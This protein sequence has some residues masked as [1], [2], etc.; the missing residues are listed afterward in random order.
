MPRF[1]LVVLVVLDSVGCGDAPDAAE[2]GDVG[3]N[4]LAH[5]IEAAGPQLPHLARLGLGSIPG[6]PSLQFS[7]A[8]ARAAYG[9]LTER[10]PAKDTMLGHWELMGVIADAPFP[11]YPEGFPSDVVAEFECRAGTRVIGNRPASGTVILEELGPEH[12]RTGHPILYTSGD[13]VF[14]LAAHEQ[15]VPVDDLYAM[16]REARAMLSGEHGVGRVIARPFV[17]TVAEGFT[18]T[19]R[20]RDF[21]IAPPRPTAL[22]LLL[23][24]GVPTHAIGKIHDIMAGRGISSSVKTDDNSAGIR[25]VREALEAPPAPFVFANL[26]DFDSRYGHRNDPAGY[27]AALEELDAAI[28]SWIEALPADGLLLLTADHGNDPTTPGTDHTRERVPLLA[29]AE[30]IEPVD[31]GTRD[32]FADV[33]RTVLDNFRA[34]GDIEGRSFLEQLVVRNG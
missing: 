24:A 29:Y 34:D 8:G 17:G 7:A 6:V 5:V 12:L 27:A 11:T 1:G 23:D 2:F 18:R 13:S 28:P 15:V 16:C 25:R 31:L 33:A 14:Q 9:R 30:G 21:A 32:S 20:R 4:T 3:A 19:P 10:A 22:D 26:V